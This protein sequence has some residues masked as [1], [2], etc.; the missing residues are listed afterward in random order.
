M[1]TLSSF[2]CILP[3]CR[4][5][6]FPFWI[7][8]HHETLNGQT[9]KA[10]KFPSEGIVLGATETHFCTNRM[11]QQIYFQVNRSPMLGLREAIKS[12]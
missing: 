12:N 9:R 2:Q 3:L 4:S 5:Y 10:T 6:I 7:D 11:T 8:G 1:T